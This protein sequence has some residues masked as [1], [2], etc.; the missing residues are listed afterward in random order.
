MTEE[1]DSNLYQRISKLYIDGKSYKTIQRYLEQDKL[2]DLESRSLLSSIHQN[3]EGDRIKRAK[4]DLAIAFLFLSINIIP[5][6]LILTMDDFGFR[7][8]TISI[9]A[10]FA[11]RPF[12]MSYINVKR[13][14]KKFDATV[15][16]R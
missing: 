7:F 13:D 16:P 9:A 4:K 11:W 12:L 1:V 5:L 10:A 15:S 14:K 8:G 3:F 6:I 2:S